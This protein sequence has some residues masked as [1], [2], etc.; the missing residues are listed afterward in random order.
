MSV[1]RAWKV[2]GAIGHRQRESFF[3]SY[4]HDFSELN[5]PRVIEVLNSDRTGTNDYS[6]IKITRGTAEE[7]EL[8]LEGQLSDGVFEN[9]RWSR[10]EEV[11]L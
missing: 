5:N 6:I 2:Y 4:R 9:S 8:E 10:A 1:T 3:R 7:C 11:S